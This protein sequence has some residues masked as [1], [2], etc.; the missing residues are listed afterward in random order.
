MIST[1]SSD[2]YIMKLRLYVGYSE[3]IKSLNV[4]TPEDTKDDGVCD[5]R[6]F[7]LY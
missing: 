5:E 1:I 4:P 2:G 6:F 7:T 3:E